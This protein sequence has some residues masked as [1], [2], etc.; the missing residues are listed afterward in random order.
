MEPGTSFTE[1]CWDDKRRAAGDCRDGALG[2]TG[3][4]SSTIAQRGESSTL[5]GNLYPGQT[6]LIESTCSENV[7]TTAS[8]ASP[9]KERSN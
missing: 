7:K 2:Y 9:T 4:G 5:S 8:E 3:P 1:S 6:L